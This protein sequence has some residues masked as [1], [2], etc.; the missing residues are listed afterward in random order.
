MILSYLP[1]LIFLLL[2]FII[3][4]IVRTGN[5]ETVK[6]SDAILI[7]GARTYGKRGNECLVSR[8]EQGAYLY[9]RGFAKYIIVSGGKT[10]LDKTNEAQTMK[11]KLIT[12]RIPEEAILLEDKSQSTY[13]NFLFAQKIMAI[14]D[15]KTIIVV[16]DPIHML[17]AGL[18]AKKNELSYT[19]SPAKNSPCSKMLSYKL[20][21]LLR[22][23][24][25]LIVYKLLGKI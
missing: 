17:R 10:Q 4:S 3:V 21:F 19:I 16:T 18:V 1:L 5:E 22:E 7:L 25:S 6:K 15:I 2:I 14:H 11:L 20:P 8:L 23:T 12:L 13:E 9:K 24:R